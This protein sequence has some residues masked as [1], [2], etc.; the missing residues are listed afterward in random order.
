MPKLPQIGHCTTLDQFLTRLVRL[1]D[2]SDVTGLAVVLSRQN[3]EAISTHQFGMNSD[4]LA[5]AG[6]LLDDYA[7]DICTDYVEH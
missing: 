5:I 1:C 4:E 2:G 6:A 7:K 3:G